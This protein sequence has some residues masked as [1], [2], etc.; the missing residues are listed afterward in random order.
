MVPPEF[1]W[2][3]GCRSTLP[4]CPATTTVRRSGR[5][6]LRRRA[7]QACGWAVVVLLWS[8]HSR[9]GIATSLIRSPHFLFQP[10]ISPLHPHVRGQQ[11]RRLVRSPMMWPCTKHFILASA[12]NRTRGPTLATLDFATKPLMLATSPLKQAILNYG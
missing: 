4:L 1:G 12:G 2:D 7:R 10:S 6:T 3:V 9:T 5:T 11:R 8:D